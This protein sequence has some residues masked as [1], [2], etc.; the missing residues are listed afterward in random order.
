MSQGVKLSLFSDGITLYLINPG[1]STR[2]LLNLIK[3]FSKL[4]E[5][6]IN[7]KYQMLFYIPLIKLLKKNYGKQSNA[8]P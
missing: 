3:T 6:K 8:L 2:K 4:A 7:M 1:D 5:F